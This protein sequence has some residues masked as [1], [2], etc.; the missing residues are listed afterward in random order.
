VKLP[1]WAD[2]R[3]LLGG[4]SLV[5][6]VVYALASDTAPKRSA[7]S[8]SNGA[9][10]PVPVVG[11]LVVEPGRTYFAV[12]TTHGAANVATSA[13]VEA[14][15]RKRGFADV[16]VFTDRPVAWPGSDE[17]DFYVRATYVAPV[18]REFPR[19]EG[20]FLGSGDV[21]DVWRA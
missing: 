20:G 3:V 16:A 13:Q 1:A 8:S 18:G 21:S 17:G 7:S 6:V 14:Y 15:A 4:G 10:G 5:A 11:P 2:W 12:V 19:H 9:G